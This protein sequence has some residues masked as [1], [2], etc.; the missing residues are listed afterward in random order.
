MKQVD[1][2]NPVNKNRLDL[3]VDGRNIFAVVI[4]I[5]TI[6]LAF[7]IP[8]L[9]RDPTLRSGLDMTSEEFHKYEE[10]VRNF[11]DEE[12][13]LVTIRG[14][15]GADDARMLQALQKITKAFKA[16]PKVTEVLSLSELRLFQKK[17]GLFGAMPVLDEVNGV[18]RLPQPDDLLAMKKAL[19]T[20]DMLVSDDGQALGIL[21]KMAEK[22]KY[23]PEAAREFKQQALDL[24]SAN[25]PA[26][27]DVRIIGAAYIR[28][29]IIR[30]NIQTG[31]IFGALCLLIG[32]VVSA[33]IF[34]SAAIT[35]ITNIILATCVVWVLGLMTL[36]R[37]P[38]NS[39]TALSFGFIP[40][41]TVEIVI[42]M[43]VRYHQF[44]SESHDKIIALKQAVR[45]LTR[46]FLICS[47]TTAVGFGSLMI[48][49]I[50]MVHQVGFIMFFGVLLSCVLAIVLTPVFFAQL[51]MLDHAH[52]AAIGHDGMSVF[53]DGVF[54]S[55]RRNHNRY[56][57]FGIAI[58]TLLFAG[59]PFIKS[60][61]QILRM[62]SDRTQEIRDI[63]QV[64]KTF[65][66]VNNLELFIQARPNAFKTADAWRKITQLGT[67]LRSIHEVAAVESFLP[68]LEYIFAISSDKKDA[69]IFK[70]PGAVPQMLML[71]TLSSEGERILRRHVNEDYS[72][73]RVSIRIHNSPDVPIG[74]T[75]A[76][77]R[78]TA[79]RV[80]DGTATVTLT[81]ELSLVA[82]QTSE[83]I[84]D[85]IKSMVIAAVLISILMMIQM[86]SVILGLICLLPN[87]PAVGTVFGMM[88]W[89]GISLDSVTVFAATVA[90][91]LAV[92]NTIHF[93]TQ[94]KREILLNPNM[95]VEEYVGK[96]YRLT[97]R[98]ILSW[99]VITLMGFLALSVSPFRPVVFF[100][101]LGCSSITV[102]LL[103]DLIF[104]QSLILS[105]ATVRKTINAACRRTAA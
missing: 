43:V 8:G 100:G 102:G 24:I 93:L 64:E 67:E 22:W 1:K 29:A 88:G 77:I 76:Q 30:Y 5:V 21:V 38:L 52:A 81:G 6:W 47:S 46:P 39:T 104:M 95:Q 75:I 51:K 56:V 78:K 61:T 15:K 9:K 28:L 58:T 7:S 35:I 65:T 63:Q 42:H 17:N 25:T 18:L 83:L 41:I 72:A 11:G 33:Y 12:F 10:F 79:T 103:G 105:S 68:L 59:A 50:P 70:D 62:L 49:S 2:L 69:D 66:P 57:L 3:I 31:I 90:I 27:T 34:K 13:I 98:Q 20:M 23:D 82:D 45:W 86:E 74:T 91:G 73:L 60:D 48:S 44:F 40:I 26:G 97:A 16:D 14:P 85:Q 55:I 37:I 4:L 101:V 94:L 92:D 99:S 53:L 87:I 96:A 84:R 54:A 80:L 19:P 89:F 71:I 36:L 32:T